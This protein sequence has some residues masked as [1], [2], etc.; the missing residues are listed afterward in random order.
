LYH[1]TIVLR[2]FNFEENTGSGNSP[3]EIF[4]SYRNC[5]IQFMAGFS[6]TETEF[7]SNC[8]MEVKKMGA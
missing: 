8:G 3:P 4:T 2:N 5:K 1:A 6:R 7:S